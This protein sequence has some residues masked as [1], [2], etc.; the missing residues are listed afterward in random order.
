MRRLPGPYSGDASATNIHPPAPD[1]KA[2]AFCD[3]VANELADLESRQFS[4]IAQSLLP[5]ATDTSLD[6]LGEI[7][8][9]PRLAVQTAS[10]DAMDQNFTWYVR[11]GTF[12]DINGG[13]DIVIPQGVYIYTVAGVN[14]PIYVADAV[15]L[16]GPP[17]RNSLA[18]SV[19]MRAPRAMRHPE[20]S[21]LRTSPVMWRI[22]LDPCW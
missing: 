8:G 18:P 7:Y 4:N 19:C 13:Q 9:V 11:S 15:Y 1:G 20:S 21:A 3:I 17:V 22:S 10:V 6:L 5:F 16:A 2:R 14:G 12:G